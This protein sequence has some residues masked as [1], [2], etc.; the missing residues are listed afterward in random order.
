MQIGEALEK[1]EKLPYLAIPRDLTLEEIAA[2]IDDLRQVRGIYVIDDQ[3]R[4][5]G[6]LSLGAIIRHLIA[7]HRKPRLFHTRSLLVTITSEKVADIMDKY[8]ISARREDDLEATV[9]RMVQSN[10]KEIPVVDES[11]KIIANLGLF[12]LWQLLGKRP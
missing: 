10:I 7:A 6:T 4:L 9:D 5:Q 12:D 2:R 8:V 3:G 11:G 1:I